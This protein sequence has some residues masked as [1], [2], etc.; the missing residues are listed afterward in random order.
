[1]PP[2]A[3]VTQ[4]TEIKPG[5]A[6]PDSSAPAAPEGS[7]ATP[8]GGKPA[9]GEDD[10]GK[11][12]EPPKT[13]LEAAQRVMAKEGKQ[14]SDEKPQPDTAKPAT[15]AKPDEKK[16]A[17]EE[18]D[19]NL[20][21][22]EHPRWKK[23]SSEHRMLKVAKEKNED[24]IK[25]LEPKAKT[26]DELTVYLRENN[27]ARDDFQQGLTIM[28]AI[29]NDPAKAFELL[30]P[31][32]ERLELTVGERLPEDLKAK[33]E[34]G[35]IDADTAKELARTRGAAAIAKGRAET[36]EQ[37][38]ARETEERQRAAD[39]GQLQSVVDTLNSWDVEWMKRD[40]DAAKLR[41]FVQDLLIV[42][43]SLK[44]PRNAEE[45]RQLA[46]AC[47][48]KARQRLTGFIPAPKPKEG[49]LPTGGAHVETSVVPKSSLEAA[50]AALLRM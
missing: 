26:F 27:L 47:V 25:A 46:E 17:A 43:G 39:D 16:G 30:R 40:P 11:I 48:A 38:Q 10:K 21:F 35:T 31:V 20:P 3:E 6:Q 28:A 24:A 37:R 15:E 14:P 42:D 9:G 12:A 19:S 29:R 45:A 34:A 41:P 2:E 4:N 13:A 32:M 7:T 23:M 18:D 5:E 8:E 50:H 36:L 49:V 1:M 44:P 33:V 22:K